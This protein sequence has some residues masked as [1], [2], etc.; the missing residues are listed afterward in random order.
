M[1]YTFAPRAAYVCANGR[2]GNRT[3]DHGVL[4]DAIRGEFVRLDGDERRREERGR[5]KTGSRVRRDGF[6]FGGIRRRRDAIDGGATRRGGG[7]ESRV[8]GIA[9]KKR[10]LDETIPR[11]ALPRR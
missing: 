7:D 11:Q 10:R 1:A 8:I 5:R 2:V 4:R 3:R 9:R 6:E